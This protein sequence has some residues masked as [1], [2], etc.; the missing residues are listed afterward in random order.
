MKNFIEK[1]FN[2]L[3]I[4]MFES[5]YNCLKNNLHYHSRSKKRV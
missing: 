4:K 1:N 2:F 3:N 5:L